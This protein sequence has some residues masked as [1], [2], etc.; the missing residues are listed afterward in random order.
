MGNTIF[1]TEEVALWGHCTFVME[2]KMFRPE[3]AVTLYPRI[4]REVKPT[5]DEIFGEC[6]DVEIPLGV[7]KE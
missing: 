5:A 7:V 1:S 4:C 2:L 3:L 6:Y